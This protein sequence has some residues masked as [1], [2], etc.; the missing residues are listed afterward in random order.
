MIA[1]S[2]KGRISRGDGW[3]E[4]EKPFRVFVTK[5]DLVP[6][7]IASELELHRTGARSL[8]N[9][10]GDYGLW[11]MKEREAAGVA[12]FLASRH[13]E[14]SN[15]KPT[16]MDRTVPMQD[17][18]ASRGKPTRGGSAAEAVCKHCGAKDLTAM[19]GQYGYYWRCGACRKNT[20][21]PKV[22]S[23]CGADGRQGHP[24]RVRKERE[25]YFRDCKACDKSETIW[26]EG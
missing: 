18:T 16:R 17:R 9:R 12:E 24:V 26:T 6:D 10:Q 13:V 21:M 25:N 11:S 7:K 14:H 20:S 4:P 1:V 15:A 19:W 2:D 8:S 22:C 3:K 5:A 23:G